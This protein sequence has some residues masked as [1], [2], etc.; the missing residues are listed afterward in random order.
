MAKFK[1][2][3]EHQL[4]MLPISL[5]D[6]LVPGTLEHTISELVD[7]HIDLSVFDARYNN[8]ETGA[9]AIHPKA[10]LKVI[11][12]AYA[13]GMISSRQIERACQENMIFIAL[14]YGYPP[15]HSTIASFI[16]SMQSEIESL[17]CNILL[18]CEELGLL[19]GTHFSLDGVKLSANVSKEWSGTFDELK[20][21]RDKLQ[22]KLQRVIAEHAQADQQPE[23]VVERQ[24]KRERRFQLQVERLNQ[25]LEEQKPKLGSE[26]KEIQS[27]V[28]DNESVK[29]P[30]SHGVIQGYN[31][32]ALVDSKHQ[33]ILAAEAF[34]SQ[35]HENLK[36]MLEGAKK[37]AVAIGNDETYFQ[38]KQLTADPN[39]H[40]LN[41]LK[42][43]Q[44]EKIDAYIPDIQYRTRD[45]RFTEQ[46]RFKDGIHGRQ[47][48][49]TKPGLFTTADFSFDP[50]K[51]VYRCPHGKELTC[52]ARHQTNRY[53]TYDIYHARPEDCAPCPLKA[54]CLSK[55][56]SSRRY[57]S[58][59][60]ATQP[61]NLI[62]EMKN[63]ID[64]EEGKRI[65]A[66]RLGVIEPVFANICVHKRMHRF[67]LR[68][69]RKVDV[70]WR[71]F[72]LVHNIGKIHTFGAIH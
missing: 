6:Q 40:S 4:V 2:L 38:G 59:P 43:C 15:D 48:P 66:R 57:L 13:R 17:F 23:V 35:D 45:P 46:E 70:Q 31:A 14:S 65:Y 22:E 3:N 42:V 47:R 37:N 68:T 10:L 24:K 16:S 29:M 69:K 51:Q 11:L 49:D 7:K 56:T 30:T 8:D 62:D 63:K 12:L 9:A 21:K 25:F 1:P 58:I 19:D 55:S 52:H 61:P 71:L 54:R 64:S 26:G 53:R 60:L 67:T 18:V 72:A 39:Y 50:D 33:V 28:I 44:D 5:Q 27:N 34:A 32:Q 20:H 41:S 36:P